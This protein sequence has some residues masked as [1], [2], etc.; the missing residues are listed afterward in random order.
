M[1]C[2]SMLMS[3]GV[4]LAGVSSGHLAVVTLTS[5][6]PPLDD[7]PGVCSRRASSLDVHAFFLGWFLLLLVLLLL[8]LLLLL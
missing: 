2:M 3:S 1:L 6:N 8:L 5:L 7:Y 4:P